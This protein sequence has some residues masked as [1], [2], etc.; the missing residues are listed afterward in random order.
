MGSIYNKNTKDL[1]S[2]LDE[3]NIKTWFDLGIFIDRFKENLPKTS[4]KNYNDYSSFS[5]HI[6]NSGIAYITFLYSI[7]GVTVEV[8][9]YTKV[10]EEIFPK[11]PVHYIAGKI[12]PEARKILNK[13]HQHFEVKEISGFNAWDLYH[14]FFFKN[15]ERGSL[16]YNQL[17]LDFWNEVLIIIKK[18]GTYFEKNQIGLIHAINVFSNPGNVSLSL[19]LVLI[20]EYFGIPVISNNHDYYWEGGNREI[21]RLEKGLKKGPRDFF[22][23]NAHLGEVFSLIE[24]L[25]P[26]ESKN[27]LTVNINNGQTRHVIEKN[28]HNPANLSEIGT[29][30]DTREYSNISKRDKINAYYQFEKILSRY[31]D[32]LV[33]YSASDVIKNGLVEKNNP[34]PILIG[35]KTRSIQSFLAENVLFIQPT[36]IISRKR[37]EIGFKLIKKL[38]DNNHFLE[39][40]KATPNLKVTI[41][42]TGPIAQGH[43]EYFEKLINRFSRMINSLDEEFRSRIYLAF[44]FSELDQ[45]NFRKRFKNPVDIPQLYS[46]SSLVLLPSK[47]EGRG[48]PIIEA[49]ACGTPIF[50]RRYFP[51]QVYSEVIGEHLPES[52][53]LR[54]IEFDGKKVSSKHV[55]QILQHVLFPHK[56]SDD[57]M[58]NKRVVNKRYSLISLKKNIEEIMLQLFYQTTPQYQ[59]VEYAKESFNE[60]AHF[61]HYNKDF[62]FLLP[63]PGRYYLPG[64]GK[65]AYM[66]KLKSLI[67][68]SYFRVEE[69]EIRGY[70]F[71][72]AKTLVEKASRYQELDSRKVTLFYNAIYQLFT[73]TGEDYKIQHDHSFAYRHRNRNYY[74]YQDYT[75][76]ELTGIVNLLC[77]KII[78]PG[79]RKTIDENSHFFT[80]WNLALSQLTSSVNL[81]IDDRNI[82]IM[83]L[84]LNIPLAIFPGDHL[85]Y[86][87]EFFALQSVRSRLRLPLHEELTSEIVNKHKNELEPVYVF[88]Q[89]IGI[90]S[91]LNVEELIDFIVNGPEQELKLLYQFNI[92]RII[93]SQ[94]LTVGIHI[95]QIGEEGLKVLGQV[96]KQ[97][98][99]VITNRA[100]ASIMTDN[101]DLDRFHIGKV[102]DDYEANFMGIPS[103]SGFIQYVPAGIRSTIG[104]PT[105]VQDAVGLNRCI[106]GELFQRLSNRY[107]MN[108]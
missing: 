26:W 85:K 57:V 81:A 42:V 102:Q 108:E 4:V 44:I 74:L 76:Q 45:D 21:D 32:T 63:G 22:F 89:K 29:A 13:N 12:Y 67:D 107:G 75:L 52:D 84:Q 49:A 88:A 106:K 104:Y 1:L 99:C 62:E 64:Y 78:N 46:I 24:I 53:R 28:G 103:D 87:L 25:F 34:K 73:V 79:K 17:I 38:F 47:T 96:K 7:D 9:K 11:I 40:L 37:I 91:W 27:Y 68:P 86:I 19:A 41:M 16:A 82:L 33:C 51:K 72:F 14:S 101:I 98:G 36:R 94:Q 50:C 93:E 77:F 69:Q 80:D 8:E 48:L 39:K 54:V 31:Q 58:H 2:Y 5:E 65:L 70:V 97:N 15:M 61:F 92:I 30:V 105:P 18:L 83:K 43:F 23:N 6:Q 35:C 55:K 3:Q 71:M 56:Y 90:G 66:H 60:Y 20:T 59:G 100:Y 10:M 95:A